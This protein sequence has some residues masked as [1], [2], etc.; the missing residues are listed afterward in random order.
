MSATRKAALAAMMI[1]FLP[2]AGFAQQHE[3]PTLRSEEQKK[4]D[5][6]IEREYERVM[7]GVRSQTAPSKYDPWQTVRPA[8]S[9][10]SKK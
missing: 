9:E 6:E 7:K 5:A 10:N 4:Q 8:A 2:V 3:K 1:A